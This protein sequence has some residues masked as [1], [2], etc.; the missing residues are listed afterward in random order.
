MHAILAVSACHMR[1]LQETSV[2]SLTIDYHT[3]ES[4]HLHL[5][6]SK[7]RLMFSEIDVVAN[8]DAFRKFSISF[9]SF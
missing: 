1:K 4:H 8:Q 6:L 2:M 9:Y 7:M 3:L 5:A